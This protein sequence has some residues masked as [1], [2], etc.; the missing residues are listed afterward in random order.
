MELLPGRFG[1]GRN[2][3]YDAPM[4]R[5]W[6]VWRIYDGLM[7]GPVI[8]PSDLA[9]V[10]LIF[11]PGPPSHSPALHLLSDEHDMHNYFLTEHNIIPYACCRL[12]P[13][14]ASMVI[15]FVIPNVSVLFHSLTSY[16][17]RA[18]QWEQCADG[19][20]SNNDLDVSSSS[21]LN[22]FLQYFSH[23]TTSN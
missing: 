15:W 23:S 21:Q 14:H 5:L 7:T 6:R 22:I 11:A 8:S 3:I 18:K 4:T 17:K 16:V 10:F 12:M 1:Q 9:T 20:N 13:T 2:G 19:N